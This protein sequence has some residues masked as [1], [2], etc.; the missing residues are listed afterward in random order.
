MIPLWPCLWKTY[1]NIVRKREDA[2][3]QQFLYFLTMYDTQGQHIWLLVQSSFFSYSSMFRPM[4]KY[5]PK[6][7]QMKRMKHFE[8]T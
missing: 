1:G 7:S 8:Q 3:Y 4:K 5:L 6:P 2:G